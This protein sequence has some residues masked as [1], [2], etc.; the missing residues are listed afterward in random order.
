MGEWRQVYRF[1][2]GKP[3]GKRPLGKLRH[4]WEHGIGMDH[5][6]KG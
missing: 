1:S 4:R 6:E 2:V 5:R 3:K